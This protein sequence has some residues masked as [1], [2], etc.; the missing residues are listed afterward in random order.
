[1]LLKRPN[2][3]FCVLLLIGSI[4]AGNLAFWISI[5][6][7]FVV[8][9]AGGKSLYI[10]ALLSI[11]AVIVGITFVAQLLILKGE[12]S[13]PL[14]YDQIAGF[15]QAFL[16]D[17][18]III[19]GAGAGARLQYSGLRD[20]SD[21]RYFELQ[22]I[23]FV[24]QFG[25]VIIALYIFAHIW[26]ALQTFKLDWLLTLTYI[27]YLLY[28]LTNPYIFDTNQVVAIIILSSLANHYRKRQLEPVRPQAKPITDPALVL[29]IP[30]SGI[31]GS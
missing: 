21:F 15:L 24:Y 28:G 20:Y 17:P 19:F 4:F 29:S 11:G 7:F 6:I 22:I 14:R 8:Y 1:M 27:C 23:Y 25:F 26:R 13:L 30:T 31:H 3:L 10:A 18:K 9:F 12:M 2:L 16:Q 5:V